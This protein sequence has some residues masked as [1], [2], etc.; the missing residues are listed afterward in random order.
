MPTLQAT[1]LITLLDYDDA[2]SLSCFISSTSQKTQISSTPDTTLAVATANGN[3]TITVAPGTG[4]RFSATQSI[5]LGAQTLTISSISG[6]VLTVSP[7]V[8]AVN[9]V[10]TVV[11]G[12][13]TYTPDWPGSNPI[14]TPALFSN[15]YA[16]VDLI[17]ASGTQ[18]AQIRRIDWF[19]S[20]N[21]ATAIA[22]ADV[23][24]S[25]GT[26][27]I[28][29]STTYGMGALTT[30]GKGALTIKKNLMT[31][32]NYSVSY[33]AK[34]TY[35]SPDNGL[36]YVITSTIDFQRT[37]IG[38]SGAAGASSVYAMM[39]YTADT[40]KNTVGTIDLTADLYVG[41]TIN[42]TGVTYQWYVSQSLQSSTLATATANGNTTITVASGHGARFTVN[43]M[44]TLG[45][46][47]LTVTAISTDTLTV[48]PAVNAVNAIGAAVTNLGDDATTVGNGWRKITS[49]T[50]ATYA[51]TNPKDSTGSAS[52][53]TASGDGTNIKTLTVGA[54]GVVSL[55][56][57]KFVATYNSIKYYDVV[58]LV[59]TTDPIKIEPLS[60]NGDIF[61]NGVVNTTLY[62]KLYQTGAEIDVYG[63]SVMASPGPSN[64]VVNQLWYDTTNNQFKKCTTGGA[65][66]VWA[67]DT[68]T[69]VYT[70]TWYKY[71]QNGNQDMTFGGSGTKTGKFISISSSE[72][73]N[74][75][76]FKIEASR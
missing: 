7:A 34:I 6:D 31:G 49:S 13:T 65:S 57:Y 25:S 28:V 76:T 61:R 75:A 15:N 37:G 67:N 43:T 32:S 35:R 39:M 51:L 24:V 62:A 70:Y 19:L 29:D 68:P 56:S 40:F 42:N 12:P 41:S 10:G 71:D 30:A 73:T 64:P 4:N 23:N 36:D 48:T 59:D 16:G 18:W 45:A 3:T 66:P 69:F 38:Q 47:T 52:A 20:T 55:R 11:T 46:Q 2:V 22:Y 26:P 50:A 9:A 44:I 58:T 54:A 63:G 5:T 8:N 60:T 14:L 74:K 72:V 17:G 33:V 21:M 1:G 53:F 27:Q